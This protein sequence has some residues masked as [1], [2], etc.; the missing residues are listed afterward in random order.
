VFFTYNIDLIAKLKIKKKQ[1]AFPADPIPRWE[2]SV[3]DRTERI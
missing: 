3:D 2:S 1:R